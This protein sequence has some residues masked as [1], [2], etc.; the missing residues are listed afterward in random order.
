M[1]KLAII[2]MLLISVTCF[3]SRWLKEDTADTVLVGPFF[4]ATDGKTP[5]T[6]LDVTGWTC[7]IFKDDDSATALTVTASAGDNDATHKAMGMYSLEL[8]AANVDTAGRFFVVIT[9]ANALPVWH[10]FMI[11]PVSTYGFVDGGDYPHVDALQVNG[12]TP[13]TAANIQ[14]ECDDALVANNLDHLAY[15]AVA[16]INMAAEVNDLSILSIM[17]A[18]DGDISAFTTATDS[19]EGLAFTA[20][21]ANTIAD[22]VW[23][24][25]LNEI[26]A[27][28]DHASTAGETMAWLRM[29][30]SFK[31]ITDGT[32]DELQFYNFAGTKILEQDIT[33]TETSVTRSN[34]RLDN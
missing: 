8:T 6:S 13:L 20:S 15:N 32:T 9:D 10:E 22:Q 18:I 16:N 19:L 7:N 31:I 2:L 11:M 24:E 25:V 12:I 21:D 28:L 23:D 26:T 3:G 29:M 33:K 17:M 34:V 1:K 14:S 27:P 30:T 4:D 5:E